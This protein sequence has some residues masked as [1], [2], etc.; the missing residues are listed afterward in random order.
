MHWI[1]G[2]SLYIFISHFNIF[3]FPSLYSYHLQAFLR[4]L[5]HPANSE[6]WWLQLFR[7]CCSRML[8]NIYNERVGQQM[9]LRNCERKVLNFAAVYTF[10][11]TSLLS[12][13]SDIFFLVRALQSNGRN[14]NTYPPKLHFVTAS[15]A[16]TKV[17]NK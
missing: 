2:L 13:C 10:I 16:K 5:P 6:V 4:H 9:V 7:T 14:F 12:F 11:N 17:T 8:A 3:H 1:K 15:V